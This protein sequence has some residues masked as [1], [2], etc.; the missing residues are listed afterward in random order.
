MGDDPLAR[1][2]SALGDRVTTSGSDKFMARCPSHDD[3]TAS[4]CIS[5]GTTHPVVLTCQAGCTTA[6]VVEAL[7]LTLVDLMAPTTKATARVVERYD[8]TDADGTLLYQV[9][10]NDPK[11]FRQ[12]R[13]D[14]RGGWHHSLGNVQRVPY[15]LAPLAQARPARVFVVEGERDVHTLAALGVPATTNS[16]G[17]GK[18]TATH[19]QALANCD[20]QQV[21]ILSDNDDPG[22]KHAEQVAALC[23]ATGIEARIVALPG[24]PIKGDVSDWLHGVGTKEQLLALAEAA[25]VW[26]PTATTASTMR[27]TLPTRTPAELAAMAVATTEYLCPYVVKGTMTEFTARAKGGKTSLLAYFVGCVVYGVECLG[28]PTIQTSVVWLTEERPATFR[29]ALAR[30][31]LLDAPR[32]H[33]VSKWDVPASTSWPEVVQ[34]AIHTCED[35]AST[36]LIV[37]TLSAWAGQT[38]DRENNS[39]DALEALEPLQRAAAAGLAVVVVRHDRKGG[40]AVGEAGRGSSAYAGAVDT[41]L[42]L[43]KPEGAGNPNR[44]K[45]DAISRFD[46][47]P[48]SVVV[49]RTIPDYLSPSPTG[50]RF[51]K[52]QY[53]VLG[54]PGTLALDAAEAAILDTLMPGTVRTEAEIT[55]AHPTITKATIA[56]ALRTLYPSQLDR[57][58]AGKK[59]SPFIYSRKAEVSFLT[60]N[61]I[62]TSKEKFT[63]DAADGIF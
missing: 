3:S 45:L 35:T 48:E 63:E 61:P 38:G 7:G 47:V 42:H 31:R 44:R 16:G 37:D 23:T 12:R 18:W 55:E 8:Y 51:E 15:H 25:P 32:L 19:A 41:L 24:L 2:R 46:G 30:A 28:Q 53:R 59:G 50:S 13:P 26:T 54:A 43:G 29:A 39:G 6:A 60:S 20:V 52:N 14:G 22:R 34:A 33:V 58:G 36:L 17:A 49:E 10:R 11:D 4:L 57:D 40:G 21:C 5:R 62:G 9:E 56:R 1:L 27:R